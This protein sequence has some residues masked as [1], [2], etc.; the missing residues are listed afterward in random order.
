M[1]NPKLFVFQII[2]GGGNG[3]ERIRNKLIP[4]EAN[5]NVPKEVRVET[6]E[7]DDERE[8]VTTENSGR[9]EET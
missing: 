6:T 7:R 4:I 1:H 5:S 2:Q 3:L 8:N 9:T